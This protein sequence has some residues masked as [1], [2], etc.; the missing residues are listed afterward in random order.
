[1]FALRANF[2]YSKNAKVRGQKMQRKCK[3]D[4]RKLP[5][6]VKPENIIRGVLLWHPVDRKKLMKILYLMHAQYDLQLDCFP[7]DPLLLSALVSFRNHPFKIKYFDL[8]I[9]KMTY[10]NIY[11]RL[12]TPNH[13]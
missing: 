8:Y 3:H 2:Y 6:D 7:L 12:L 9:A 10:V 5:N 4:L 11:L 13:S 1:M